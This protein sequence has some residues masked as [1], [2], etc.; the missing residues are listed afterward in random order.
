[1]PRGIPLSQGGSEW[2][3][4]PNWMSLGLLTVPLTCRKVLL[5]REVFGG[6]Y[7]RWLK[8]L[9]NSVRNSMLNL[10]PSRSMSF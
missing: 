9:K 3:L 7:W 5:P 10:P 1:M 4:N 2:N 8:M 6:P